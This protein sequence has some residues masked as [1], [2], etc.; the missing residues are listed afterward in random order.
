MV[1]LELAATH[2]RAVAGA[3]LVDGGVVPV[4]HGR[5]WPEVR[6]ALAPPELAG[7]DVERFRALMPSFWGGALAVTPEIEAIVLEVMHVRRDGTIRPRLSRANHLRILRAI[8]EQDPL[9]LHRRLRVPAHA[10]VTEGSRSRSAADRERATHGAARAL[11]AAGAPTRLS[12][13]DGIHDVPLQHPEE[14]ARRIERFVRTAV[15]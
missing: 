13:I 14:L 11:R 2:P 5:P 1:A 7:M 10:I 15:G 8:W 6:D 4:G 9:A 12:W 3:V